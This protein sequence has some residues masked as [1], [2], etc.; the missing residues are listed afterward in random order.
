MPSQS[1]RLAPLDLLTV[2]LML[3]LCIAGAVLLLQ[4]RAQGSAAD[5]VTHTRE[6][7]QRVARANLSVTQAE[8]AE[9]G[10]LLTAD[11][12]DAR[13]YEAARQAHQEHLHELAL[14]TQDNPKQQ[15]VL[16]HLVSESE[17]R[18]DILGANIERRQVGRRNDGLL[19][20]GAASMARL[21]GYS[22]Q[23]QAE[24]E[25]LLAERRA[26]AL[27]ARLGVA[28]S[29]A[30]IVGLSLTLAMVLLLRATAGRARDQVSEWSSSTRPSALEPGRS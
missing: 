16:A 5:W 23:L 12:V 30:V 2:L 14:L 20:D 3:G 27:A 1:R 11:A 21:A 29:A 10:F 28:V 24:E 4:V 13:R 19:T 18:L 17:R 22:A 6:V 26:S 15:A 7:L 8:A 9:R 25:R